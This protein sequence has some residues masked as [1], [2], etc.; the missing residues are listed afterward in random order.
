MEDGHLLRAECTVGTV[1]VG[2]RHDW[3]AGRE[4]VAQQTPSR[5][6][7]LRDTRQPVGI[8]EHEIG[9]M[10]E[11]AGKAA[12]A[13]ASIFRHGRT[14]TVANDIAGCFEP[15]AVALPSVLVILDDK[16]GRRAAE[17]LRRSNSI[18]IFPNV[19]G[20]AAL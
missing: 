8:K 10:A 4:V 17:I 6:L 7:L 2:D 19:D 5:F 1:S 16:D 18:H 15:V 3:F 12:D 11:R 13:Q 14:G 9:G 20:D